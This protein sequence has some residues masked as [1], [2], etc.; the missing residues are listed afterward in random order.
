[1]TEKHHFTHNWDEKNKRVS[2]SGLSDFDLRQTL[3][4]GQ[5]FRWNREQDGSYTGVAFSRV[6]NI[7]QEDRDLIIE[8]CTQ[9][10]FLT[11]WVEYFDLNRDYG[12]IKKVLKADDPVMKRVIS[13]GQGIRLLK[14]DPWETLISFIISQNANIPR[15]KKCIESLCCQFGAPIQQYRGKT[16]FAFPTPA[17]II[18]GEPGALGTCRFGYREDYILK[19]A[20][21]IGQDGGE[22]LYEA[23]SLTPGDAEQYLLGLPGVGPKV[24]GCILLFAMGSYSSFPIDVWMKRIMHQLYGLDEGN[25]AQIAAFAQDKYGELGGFAQQYLFYYARE[26]KNREE[27]ERGSC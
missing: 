20:K 13:F 27:M 1:M 21:Q 10:D 11:I 5:C 6:I 25:L 24:A 15:I 4:C 22:T 17:A 8:N 7:R 19:A 9:D 14:Q 3:E 23:A 26:G 2:V 18:E 12:K 16:Y